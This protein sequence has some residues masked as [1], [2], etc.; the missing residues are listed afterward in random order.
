[1]F[2]LKGTIEDVLMDWADLVHIESQK[3]FVIYFLVFN[4]SRLIFWFK[5]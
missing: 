2:K 5:L 4:G 3:S 1:M